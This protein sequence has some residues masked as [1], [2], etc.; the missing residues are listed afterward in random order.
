MFI[1]AV[2][3]VIFHKELDT[4]NVIII[5]VSLFFDYN[6]FSL[7]KNRRKVPQLKGK[8]SDMLFHCVSFTLFKQNFAV[9]KYFL[10]T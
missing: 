9:T 10:C 6:F 1:N 5:T 4:L 7:K 3:S 8:A 2:Y